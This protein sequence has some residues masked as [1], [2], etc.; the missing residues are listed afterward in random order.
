MSKSL[1]LFCLPFLHLLMGCGIWKLLCSQAEIE[2]EKI[3]VGVTMEA[4]SIFDA[5][6]KT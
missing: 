4:Q 3:G 2:A 5:L 6:Y 1:L